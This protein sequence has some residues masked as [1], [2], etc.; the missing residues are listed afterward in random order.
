MNKR[1]KKVIKESKKLMKKIE[2]NP[3]YMDSIQK[4]A[5]IDITPVK[6]WWSKYIWKLNKPKTYGPYKDTEEMMDSRKDREAWLEDKM[7]TFWY[8]YIKR[9]WEY[10]GNVRRKIKWF[11]QRG[12][13]GWADYDV[14]DVH[15]YLGTIIPDMLKWLRKNKHGIPMQAFRPSDPT[16]KYGGHTKRASDLAE[17]RWNKELDKMIY[18]FE[19][20]KRI[21]VDNWYYQPTDKWTKKEFDRYNKIWIGWKY[22]PVPRAM[23]KSECRRYEEGWKSF[24]ENF[25]SLWD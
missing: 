4:G 24:Q 11:F 9:A 1:T 10:P 14:W 12:K 18:T 17:K 22:K 20:A 2:V 6:T 3:E 23:T 21:S 15:Y 5:S 8:R 13:R 16:N 25:F 19:V 7:T